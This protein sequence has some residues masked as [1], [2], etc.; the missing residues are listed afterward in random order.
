MK[1]LY[2]TGFRKKKVFFSKW[3]NKAPINGNP[4]AEGTSCIFTNEISY[5]QSF[6]VFGGL[7]CEKLEKNVRKVIS[8]GP[9]TWFSKK[10]KKM[11][12]FWSKKIKNKK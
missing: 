4:A 12:M 5:I 6:T 8:K 1:Q 10:V 2:L 7:K 3:Y 9:G 11:V